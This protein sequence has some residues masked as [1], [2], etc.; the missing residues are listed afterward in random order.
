MTTKKEKVTATQTETKTPSLSF[1]TGKR[2]GN[3]RIFVLEVE[4]NEKLEAMKTETAAYFGDNLKSCEA[5]A[6]ELKGAET[7]LVG[8]EMVLLI[9]GHQ[10]IDDVKVL[11]AVYEREHSQQAI[12]RTRYNAKLKIQELC[13]KSK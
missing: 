9:A 1:L 10:S 4:D 3:G 7:S 2:G 13:E 6:K 11:Y 5:V 12:T 8:A